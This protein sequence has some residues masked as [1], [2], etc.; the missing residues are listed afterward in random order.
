[1]LSKYSPSSTSFVDRDMIMRFRGGGVG[2][3]STRTATNK[4]LQD[5]DRLDLDTGNRSDD[6]NEQSSESAAVGGPSEARNEGGDDDSE[7]ENQ[8]YDDGDNLGSSSSD[9]VDLRG[10]NE[11][12]GGTGAVGI[13]MRGKE[14]A[15]RK[16][17]MGMVTWLMMRMAMT[18]MHRQTLPMTL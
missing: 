5:R 14:V 10:S 15:T 8:R 17:T 9:D 4:F 12:K 11:E 1:M 13:L 16:K 18:V 3:T 6:E 7:S 2:H